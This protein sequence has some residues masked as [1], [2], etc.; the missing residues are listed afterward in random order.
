MRRLVLATRNAGKVRELQ[1]ALTELGIE[2][3]PV[4]MFPDAPEVEEDGAT[5][6]EN[7][8]K[9]ARVLAAHTGLP[10]VADDSG[11][12][13]KALGGRPGVH[14]ARYAGP[15][16][17]A[18]ANV[19]RLLAEM[20]AIPDGSRSAYFR[21]VIAVVGVPGGEALLSGEIHGMVTREPMGT[22]G[23]GY[24]PVFIPQGERR[25]FA[26]MPLS[27][28]NAISHRG[29]AVEELRKWLSQKG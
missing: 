21:T 1:E 8:M 2:L 7:A 15:E 18:R 5:L 9:K 6:E 19:A 13:V 10:S 22:E 14:S 25:T 4:S 12:F 23:F 29:K 11:L 28:K 3:V 26:E 17:D 24:D 16:G 27:E 20:S